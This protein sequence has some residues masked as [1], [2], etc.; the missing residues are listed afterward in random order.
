[1]AEISF[2]SPAIAQELQKKYGDKTEV[3]KINIQHEEDVK[4]FVMRIEK[5]HQ[6]AANSTLSAF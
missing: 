1:M 4:N 6:D 3:I 5:A 2:S